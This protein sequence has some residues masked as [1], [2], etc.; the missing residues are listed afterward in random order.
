M[1]E[2]LSRWH[3]QMISLFTTLFIALLG[4]ENDRKI[5]CV[6]LR[7][8]AKQCLSPPPLDELQLLSDK[9]C[10]KELAR[11]LEEVK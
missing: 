9:D 6:L 5:P 4:L 10:G 2:I 11:C 8:G 1:E 3:T 7:V